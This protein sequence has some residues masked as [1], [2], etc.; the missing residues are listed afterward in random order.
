MAP[1]RVI[2]ARKKPKNKRPPNN[3]MSGSLKSLKNSFNPGIIGQIE[4]SATD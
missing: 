4:Q 1:T 2:I 3:Q